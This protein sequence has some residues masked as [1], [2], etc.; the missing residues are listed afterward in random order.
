MKIRTCE[1][2]GCTRKHYGRGL[3]SMHH[4]RLRRTGSP[5]TK[6]T[7]ATRADIIA[8]LRDGHSNKRIAAELRCDKR[9]VA[10]IRRE[11][12]LPTYVPTTQTR[13]L[14]QKW[15]S[16]TRPLEG[17]HLEWLGEHVGRSGSP[18]L[19]YREE[20]FSPA[21]VAF[22]IRTGRASVGNTLPECGMRH[23]VAPEHV[24]DAP[25]RTRL[26]EQYRYLT[27]GRPR[28]TVCAH[29]HDQGEHGRIQP[30]GG[31]YC[32]LCKTLRKRAERAAV[33][34]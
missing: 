28:P 10:D 32:Q 21:A 4:L 15:A 18:V 27:G 3:C 33:A 26:R 31:A 7:Y 2:D 17:G 6:T 34:S 20:V 22:Q 11:L 9:R 1:L 5:H 12:G 19:R 14:E 16:L 13:T 8:M 23:C 30:N 24:E 25:G 29:G